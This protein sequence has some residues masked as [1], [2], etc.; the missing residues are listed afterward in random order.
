MRGVGKV[1]EGLGR[2]GVTA[3]NQAFDAGL[4]IPSNPLE[5]A[6]DA[7]HRLGERVL[8]SRTDEAKRREA[9]SRPGGDLDKPDTWTFGRNPSASGLALQGLNALGSSAIPIAASVAAGPAGIGARMAG[10][11]AGGAMGGGNA[12]EQAR[13]TIDG[14][15][16]QQLAAASSAYRDLI[17]K[18]FRQE[19]RA[20]VRADAENAAFVRTVPVSAIGGAATGK[21]L[22]P[23]GR[24]LGDRGVLAQTAGK[25]ALAGTEEAL[26]EVGEGVATQKGINAG[27][28]MDLDP[29]AG[30][31]GNAA[32]GFVAGMGPGAVHGAAEGVRGDGA[33]H[34]GRRRCACQRQAV[35]HGQRRASAPKAGR[36]CA[37]AALRERIHRAAWRGRACAGSWCRTRGGGR[38]GEG[39]GTPAKNLGPVA[40]ASR[41]ASSPTSRC[42]CARAA[43]R[44]P[45]SSSAWSATPRRPGLAASRWRGSARPTA[46]GI[47]SAC[48]SCTPTRSPAT[49][50]A[51]RPTCRRRSKAR[52]RSRYWIAR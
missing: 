36:R 5:G 7:T 51:R 23:A 46:A 9:D 18:G 25:A 44:S 42:T 43:A 33:H 20:R 32:L 41:Q 12:I 16:D 3:L 27:A 40:R 47:S 31:F 8:A 2:V 52:R 10:A 6:A 28:S 30:S 35:H 50:C 38:R 17:A 14:M 4:D 21:I 49:P 11:T 1:A 48:R 29:L 22:S 39:C 24:V 34:G 26:Q 37:G 15:D 13:E 45:S 19:A